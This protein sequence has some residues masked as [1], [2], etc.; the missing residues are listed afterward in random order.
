MIISQKQRH[1]CTRRCIPVYE[2][3]VT[4]RAKHL[5]IM[6]LLNIPGPF[7]SGSIAT[8]TAAHPTLAHRYDTLAISNTL[9][10]TIPDNPGRSEFVYGVVCFCE[11]R[12][13][14]QNFI[15][16]AYCPSYL[17]SLTHRTSHHT[18][19]VYPH[20]EASPED[21]CSLSDITRSL[22]DTH[23]TQRSLQV[24]F[25]PQRSGSFS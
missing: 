16:R 13:W 23:N 8:T 15:R 19:P 24:A 21:D 22:T 2:L 25:Q 9:A 14:A 4:W 12:H 17:V 3:T 1:T 7:L 11:Q 6:T 5:P 18:T 20:T 10:P